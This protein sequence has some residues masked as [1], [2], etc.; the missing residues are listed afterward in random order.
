MES[1]KKEI[2]SMKHT[3]NKIRNI[4]QFRINIQIVKFLMKLFET[5]PISPEKA[6]G[7]LSEVFR[8][9]TFREGFDQDR[10]KIMFESSQSKY[11]SE[12]EYPWDN[13]F[14]A[15][16]LP[17]LQGKVA[18]DLGCFTG[19]RSI[20]WAERYELAKVYGIDIKQHYID[21]ATQFAK[22]KGVQSEFRLG[23]GELLPFEDDKFDAILSFDVFEHVQNVEQTLLECNRVLKKNGHLFLVFPGYFHPIE[24]HLSLVTNIPCVHYF[25]KGQTLIAA[26][27]EILE[28]R[29]DETYWYRRNSPNLASWERGNTINGTTFF[30][31]LRLVKNMN[32]NIIYQSRIPILGVGR[33]VTKKPI[34]RLVSFLMSPFAAIPI[35]EEFF[36]HRISYILE[37]FD[38]YSLTEGVLKGESSI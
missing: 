19:G 20:A 1:K 35:L 9:S 5:F 28:E 15:N 8:H 30:T 17:L 18:L 16:L 25:F 24:H 31:F 22:V 2:L 23:K 38:G 14:G 27:N 37:K 11:Q 36:C 3:N 10:K 7:D 6:V 34:L 21:A 12:M 29:G 26:Y 33:N 13:Y 4:S 32:W